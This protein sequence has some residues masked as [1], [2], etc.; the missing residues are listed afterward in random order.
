MLVYTEWYWSSSLMRLIALNI[1][2]MPMRLLFM[3][4]HRIPFIRALRE[5]VLSD[6]NSKNSCSSCTTHPLYLMESVESQRCLLFPSS[7]SYQD[8]LSPTWNPLFTNTS[9]LWVASVIPVSGLSFLT[10]FGVGGVSGL[11]MHL[12]CILSH[13]FFG[14]LSWILF[15]TKKTSLVSCKHSLCAWNM[16]PDKCTGI[17]CLVV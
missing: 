13:T 12:L 2:T 8:S 16:Q 14:K 1:V 7:I 6:L 10:H 9:I 5:K 11:L 3:K 4:L 17:F 15:G